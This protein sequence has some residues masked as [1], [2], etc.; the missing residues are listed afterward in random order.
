MTRRTIVITGAGDGIGA[1]A[2]RRLHRGGDDVVLVGR[3]PAKT[4]ALA[5]ELRADFETTDRRR[6]A[7]AY[8]LA[9]L[10]N[11]L[12]TRELH[13]CY[14]AAGLSAAVAHP[15]FVNT[16]IAHASGSRVLVLMQRTPVRRLIATPDRGAGQL[17]RLASSM[18]GVDWAPGEC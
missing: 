13:R 6:P 8:A 14:G 17:V 18:P 1:A 7:T 9:K 15:G 3:S 2:A 16:N 10:A 11:V 5:A 12:F 4:A